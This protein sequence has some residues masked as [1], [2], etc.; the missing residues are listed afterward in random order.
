MNFALATAAGSFVVALGLAAPAAAHQYGW[1]AFAYSP[2][3]RGFDSAAGDTQA[4]V[5]ESV[6][7]RCNNHFGTSDCTIGASGTPCVGLAYAG[8][9]LWGGGS[10]TTKQAAI[11]AAVARAGGNV[12]PQNASGSCTWDFQ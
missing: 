12:P 8:N 1:V 6:I 7:S 11:D 5:E 10:G 9:D 2:T 4:A 3:K